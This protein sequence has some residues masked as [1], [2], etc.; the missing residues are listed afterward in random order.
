MKG[1]MAFKVQRAGS[2]Y[3]TIGMLRDLGCNL[4]GSL[5]VRVVTFFWGRGGG[6]CLFLDVLWGLGPFGLRFPEPPAAFADAA[7]LSMETF[8]DSAVGSAQ[9]AMSSSAWTP[10]FFQDVDKLKDTTAVLMKNFEDM[11]SDSGWSEVTFTREKKVPSPLIFFL[12]C[13]FIPR[14]LLFPY[15][16]HC[17]SR[18]I[19]FSSSRRT[20]LHLSLL[21]PFPSI[22][23]LPRS[24][25]IGR[26][27]RKIKSERGVTV[28]RKRTN[29]IEPAGRKRRNKDAMAERLFIVKA[30]GTISA[31]PKQVR[32][33]TKTTIVRSNPSVCFPPPK[34][35]KE[36][37]PSSARNS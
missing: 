3:L 23:F 29:S 10:T 4:K 17:A 25:K 36:K 15:H 5:E 6:G 27:P 30:E 14:T 2:Q 26:F 1:K 35:T 11:E 7:R 33:H 37:S 21:P 9:L 31:P 19:H 18:K 34:R 20:L 24:Q 22:L 16:L 28:W 8:V 12:I 13:S 32:T